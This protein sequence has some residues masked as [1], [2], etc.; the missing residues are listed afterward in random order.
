MITQQQTPLEHENYIMVPILQMLKNKEFFHNVSAFI[1]VADR[2]IKLNYAEDDFDQILMNLMSKGGSHVYLTQNDMEELLHNYQQR[3]M[4]QSN[5]IKEL[6]IH[7][8]E[9]VMMLAQAFIK[10]AGISPEV[11]SM[12]ES[13]NKRVQNLIAKTRNI[14]SILDSFKKTCSEEFFK[15]TFTNYVCSVVLNHFEW[16]TPLILDKLMLASTVCDLSLTSDDFA[17]LD[18]FE[19]DQG[20]L[21]EKVKNHPFDAVE[22]LRDEAHNVTLETITIIQQHHER[23]DGK[24]FP[25]GIDHSR[26]NQLSALFIVSHKFV[27]LVHDIRTEGKS[28]TEVA[29]MVKEQYHGGFFNKASRAL[30]TEIG[31]LK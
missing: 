31:K 9:T 30:V 15:I 27:D 20:P 4:D 24:G 19:S 22:L 3:I 25:M 13:S 6:T 2:F 1:K 16:K 10:N 7:E 8:D 12:I 26:I 18:A 29:E 11:V 5:I 21:T 23:P 14:K 17:D 28:Y